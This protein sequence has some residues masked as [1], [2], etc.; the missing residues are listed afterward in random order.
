MKQLLFL[1][2]VQ[3][4]RPKGV[5]HTFASLINNIENGNQILMHQE[6]DRWLASLPFYHIGGFQI[7]CRS[8][9]Y[10]CL[11]IIPES[12]QTIHLADAIE[13]N[14]P[15]HLSLVS[16]Q[17]ERLIHQKIKPKNSLKSFFNWWWIY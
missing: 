6:S 10:G 7:I 15:T 8:L 5:V 2:P 4:D 1:L 11:I 12:L 3:Q 9:F 14:N 13:K 17:L 16:T